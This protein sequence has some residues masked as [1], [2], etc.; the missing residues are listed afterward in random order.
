MC[1]LQTKSTDTLPQFIKRYNDNVRITAI[2]AGEVG[3]GDDT[4]EAA[5]KTKNYFRSY[6]KKT[7]EFRGVES[8]H[9]NWKWDQELP[10][11]TRVGQWCNCTQL[12]ENTISKF[13]QTG[14]TPIIIKLGRYVC[15]RKDE[16]SRRAD[17]WFVFCSGRRGRYQCRLLQWLKV[18]HLCLKQTTCGHLHFCSEGWSPAL[19]L[20][21]TRN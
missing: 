10:D 16:Q 4:R 7:Q 9:T 18:V 17:D 3:A 11:D 8:L 14:E 12:L 15:E 21:W 6:F 1:W 2:M 5:K 20:H 19:L 13:A